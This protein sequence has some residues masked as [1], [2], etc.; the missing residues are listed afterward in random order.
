MLGWLAL[1]PVLAA[2]M[3]LAEWRRR[4]RLAQFGQL[5]AM[6]ILSESVSR[7]KRIVKNGLLLA[8]FALTI[9][10]L[11]RPQYGMTQRKIPR[12][13]LDVMVALDVSSSMFSQ[14]I[15]PSRLKRAQE[16][17]KGLIRT[18]NGDR[19]GIIAFAGEAYLQCPLTTDYSIAQQVLGLVSP[20]SIPVPGTAIGRAIDLAREN[21]EK[22]E[23]GQKV[24]VLLTDGEDQGSEPLKAA[25]QA[26]KEKIVIHAIGIGSED[27]SPIPLPEG[28]LQKDSEGHAVN[29]RL[30][31]NTLKAIAAATGGVAIKA[32]PLGFMELDRIAA[33]IDG[34]QQRTLSETERIVYRERYQWF[35]FPALLLIVLEGC[36]GDRK[37]A[38]QRRVSL[39]DRKAVGALI[40]L[41][42]VP[43]AAN[44]AMPDLRLKD[45]VAARNRGANRLMEEGKVGEA[46]EAYRQAQVEA[47]SKPELHYNLGLALSR[48]EKFE[49]ALKSFS[50][51]SGANGF[52][53]ALTHYNAG[54][55]H[56]QLA[57]KARESNEIPRAIKEL[58]Q[59][60]GSYR[61]ALKK[62]PS[63]R[64]AKH[65]LE[66]AD[67]VLKEL[68]ALQTPTPTPTPT[69]SVTP[70]A[71]PTP[72]P[73]PSPS[74]SPTPGGSP[75]PSPTPGG[76][77][78]PQP[79]P[80]ASPTPGGDAQDQ[81]EPS[82]EEQ[83]AERLLDQ[84]EDENPRQF[85]R[86]FVPEEMDP[87][88][89]VRDW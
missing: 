84:L 52:L 87:R 44:A 47:P 75:T 8:A 59:A 73:S 6:Q 49:D 27:G 77:P 34:L 26:A 54:W 64:Q 68:K 67:A 36:L 81:P 76:S 11:S 62:S 86:L 5:P 29:S 31:F 78:T 88:R 70:T 22:N 50:S 7:A 39:N 43:A 30:D 89:W 51:V 80:S 12:K 23:Q 1:L 71:S 85:E 17:L 35:L 45:P 48:Q 33:E 66:T 14:D 60:I 61:E 32:R 10:A 25:E 15:Q 46:F 13:G 21:F 38:A 56:Y 3:W 53:E 20:Q 4:Q 19:V 24:L 9:V 28:G 2:G 40:V 41:M 58:E 82:L 83:Q 69:P 79:S 16:Q 42:I 55:N 74:P 37:R 72:T 18:M 63:D 57:L 65:N